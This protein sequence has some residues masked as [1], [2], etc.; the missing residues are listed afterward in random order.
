[1]RRTET[2]GRF[3]FSWEALVRRISCGRFWSRK[4]HRTKT[5]H[6]KWVELKP[7]TTAGKTSHKY[8]SEL[9]PPTNKELKITE[10]N[11]PQETRRTKTS[12]KK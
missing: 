3:Y 5:S 2:C 8:I 11:L 6:K 7:P 12:H 10:L 4:T 9:K 1:M